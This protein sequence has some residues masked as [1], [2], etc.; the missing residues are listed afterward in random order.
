MRKMAMVII[1]KFP[2]G[3][4]GGR[5]RRPRRGAREMNRFIAT[6]GDCDGDGDGDDDV[7]DYGER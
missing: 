2:D 5:S 1:M 4:G 6:D 3:G 7:D